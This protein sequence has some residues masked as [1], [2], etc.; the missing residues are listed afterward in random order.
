MRVRAR[1]F[2]QGH[3]KAAARCRNSVLDLAQV[4]PSP[5]RG[6][7]ERWHQR[8]LLVSVEEHHADLLFMSSAASA[9]SSVSSTC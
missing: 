9:S 7:S 4:N 1:N 3:T 5:L 2:L 6:V 8:G